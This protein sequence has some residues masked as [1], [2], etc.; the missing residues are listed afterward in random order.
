[1]NLERVTL[2]GS[3]VKIPRI[4]FG[5][6]QLG[7]H[8]W[9]QIDRDNISSAIGAAL[10][11]GNCLFDTADCYGL[12]LSEN[13]LGQFVADRRE[14]A[15]IA[16]KFGV[17][18]GTDKKTFY[19]NSPEW[20]D[21][22][23]DQSLRRL[24]TDYIDLYQVH[25][26]DGKYPISE[27]FNYLEKKRKQGKI[28]YYGVTNIDIGSAG[29]ER[30]PEGLAGFSNE[31]SLANR[32]LEESILVGV[33]LGLTF[34]SHGSLGQGILTGKYT[35]ETEFAVDDRRRRSDYGNFHGPG[36][37]QNMALVAKMK[38]ML[39][40]YPDATLAQMGCRWILETIAGSVA[41]IGIKTIEQWEDALLSLRW[42]FE[43]DDLAEL[44]AISK[45][46]IFAEP[47]SRQI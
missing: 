19:D 1:M 27:T 16:T 32:T 3:N 11:L 14:D 39:S 30:I 25:Y 46:E 24:N 7:E 47:T 42:R 8:G 33:S 6:A 9:G 23:L 41:L 20:I 22:A 44:A 12:G 36:L 15:F 26:P 13:L 29:L 18:I 5:G 38:S 21:R 10:E 4:G 43:P 34:I 28:R 2:G 37:D 31:Y 40:K 45:N 35:E 17:R